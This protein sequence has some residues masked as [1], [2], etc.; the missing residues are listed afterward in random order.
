MKERPIKRSIVMY[1]LRVRELAQARGLDQSKLSRK[2]DVAYKTIHKL[3]SDKEDLE[4]ELSTLR[5]LAR[6]LGVKI[7][8][9]IEDHEDAAAPSR[10][11]D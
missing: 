11:P 1:R 2:A 6:T 9:L 5:K 10:A 3:W 7:T 4:A 8:D